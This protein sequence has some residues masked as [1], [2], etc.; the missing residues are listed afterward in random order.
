MQL[1]SSERITSL[2]RI[3]AQKALNAFGALEKAAYSAIKDFVR[4][5]LD[6]VTDTQV[7][8]FK[9]MIIPDKL[10]TGGF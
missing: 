8:E 1:S 9:G 7:V 10:K 2:L 4:K 6:S 5:V 3:A